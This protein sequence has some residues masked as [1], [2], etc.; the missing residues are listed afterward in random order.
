[1]EHYQ[2]FGTIIYRTAKNRAH[3]L[4]PSGFWSDSRKYAELMHRNW[5]LFCA[6]LSTKVNISYVNEINKE[7][8][9]QALREQRDVLCAPCWDFNANEYMIFNVKVLLDIRKIR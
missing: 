8:I 1:M 5:P 6:K 3:V 4:L 7:E 9:Y 2:K